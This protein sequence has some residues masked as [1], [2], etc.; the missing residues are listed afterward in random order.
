MISEKEV[1]RRLTDAFE[2]AADSSYED[3]IREGRMRAI[4][5]FLA[6]MK[7]AIEETKQLSPNAKNYTLKLME[8]ISKE[9]I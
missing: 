1:L 4:S 7:H 3:G 9:V 8:R 5:E 2:L 6:L